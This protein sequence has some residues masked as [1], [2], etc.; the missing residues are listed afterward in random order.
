[1]SRKTGP[2]ENADYFQMVGRMVRGMGK[3]GANGDYTDLT[4]MAKVQQMM[5]DAMQAAVDGMREQQGY[6]WAD[7]GEGLGITRQAAQQRFGRKATAT[8][9][10]ATA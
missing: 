1:M 4:E 2:V 9:E 5:T 10:E 3:R 7:I 8:T 6:S